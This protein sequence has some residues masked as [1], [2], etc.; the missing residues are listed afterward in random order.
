[1]NVCVA[2]GAA[3]DI[4]LLLKAVIL[5]NG[6]LL[7]SQTLVLMSGPRR[8]ARDAEGERECAVRYRK[9][10]LVNGRNVSKNPYGSDTAF[11]SSL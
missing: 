4:S 1:M 3:G 6:G 8:A 9:T 2:R 5:N 11:S 7:V 10:I